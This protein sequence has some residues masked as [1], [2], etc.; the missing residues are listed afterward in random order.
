MTRDSYKGRLAKGDG[1]AAV[2][3]DE[4]VSLA[5]IRVSKQGIYRCK[6]RLNLIFDLFANCHSL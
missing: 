4:E 5:G 1:A 6:P 2:S 3:G